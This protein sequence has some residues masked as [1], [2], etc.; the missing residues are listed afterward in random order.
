MTGLHRLPA[1]RPGS[2]GH[3][4]VQILVLGGIATIFVYTLLGWAVLN[5]KAGRSAVGR[6]R[7]IQLA[8]AGL[9][10]YR[11]HLAH[12]PTDFQDGTGQAGPYVHDFQDKDGNTIGQFTL[13]L[14]PPEVGS[15]EVSV[16]SSGRTDTAYGP[17]RHL[18]ATLTKPSFARYAVAANDFMR[19]GEGTE[20]NGPI[21]SNRGIR[22]DGLAHNIV[23]SAVAEYD[24]PDDVG[25]EE[26]GVHTH[27]FPADPLPPSTVPTRSDVFEVGRQFPVAAVDFD[28][29]TADFAEMRTEADESGFY[30]PSAGAQG[31][32][33]TF[34]TDG[35]FDL[36]KVTKLINA[37]DGCW[38]SNSQEGW[39]TW[40]IEN[41]NYIDNF[42][43]PANGLIYLEDD[44]FVDGQIDGVRVTVVAAFLPDNPPFRKNIIVNRD[45]L[46]TRYDGTD[47]VGLIAQGHII[48]GLTS[49][50]DLRIDAAL[51]A[52]TGKVGR[53]YY[54]S[55]CSPYDERHSLTLWGMIAT[56]MRYG[57]A[58][59]DGTGYAF[60]YINYDGS[61]FLS[62]PP[63]FPLTS[64]SYVTTSWGER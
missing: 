8:E 58:Y 36:H 33:I 23:S 25:D 57:F 28:G 31:Y 24:D 55:G 14:T 29:L 40:S 22:F 51:I 5:H 62:P 2:G 19:F 54:P 18:T 3:V 56:A 26:F 12:A 45:L 35:T 61:L 63:S 15:S 4:L 39:G 34:R 48:T 47:S 52:Q 37:P 50:D 20:V 49:Q 41:E 42:P 59:T 30:R 44:T 17:V 16:R 21:H 32:H 11:W 38:N 64:E 53:F 6:E 13:E 60:R 1:S 10:Y 7:A 9:D 27:L 43:I 46:Y